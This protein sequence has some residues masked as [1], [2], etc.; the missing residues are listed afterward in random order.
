MT[1]RV[2]G[3]G[4]TSE[5]AFSATSAEVFVASELKKRDEAVKDLLID[6]LG[7]ARWHARR[8]DIVVVVEIGVALAV[9]VAP[10]HRVVRLPRRVDLLMPRIVSQSESSPSVEPQTV[11]EASCLN[12]FRLSGSPGYHHHRYLHVSLTQRMA[13]IQDRPFSKNYRCV[14][15][16]KVVFDMTPIS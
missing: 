8:R 11:Q 12:A 4:I 6:C 9:V 13:T 10:S 14:S 1:S 3:V 2:G 15:S 7:A 16:R 5:D